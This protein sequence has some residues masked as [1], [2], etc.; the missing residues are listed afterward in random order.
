MPDTITHDEAAI[1][2]RA[3]GGD[4]GAFAN[5][6]DLHRD[7]VYAQAY[8]WARSVHDAED[9]LAMAFFETWRNRTRV[10]I[11][12]GSIAAWLLVTTNHI[13]Q[14]T[15]RSARRHRIAMAKIPAREDM[16][17]HAPEILAGIDQDATALKV[18][19]AF[20]QLKPRDRDVL[21]LVVINELSL[22]HASQ[23]LGVPVGT[24][25]SRLSR[26]K[27]RLAALTGPLGHNET[28]L[29]TRGAK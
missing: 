11:V 23:A 29:F 19:E 21:T 18:R 3:L 22:D 25:K 5:I 1:W 10:R 13:A 28:T 6:Y 16:D 26:A 15:A 2:G 7:K 24:V 20:T 12:N 14:N 27:A 9:I 4:P 17:D 8:R